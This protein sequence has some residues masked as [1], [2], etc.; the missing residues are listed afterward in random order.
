[1]GRGIEKY[2]A[3]P[4]QIPLLVIALFGL[5]D[6]A[7]RHHNCIPHPQH[8]VQINPE[9]GAGRHL[10]RVGSISICSSS[11]SSRTVLGIWKFRD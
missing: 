5:P 6:L 2:L 1:M 3:D 10:R 9:L 8:G 4:R 11:P 7:D